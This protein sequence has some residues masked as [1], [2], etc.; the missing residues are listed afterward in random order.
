MLEEEVLV[1]AQEDQAREVGQ[2]PRLRCAQ[3]RCRAAAGA[4]GCQAAA[5]ACEGAALGR[6]RTLM[7]SIAPLLQLR[8]HQSPPRVAGRAQQ[9]R[10][11]QVASSRR[12]RTA[13]VAGRGCVSTRL[14]SHSSRQHDAR[15]FVTVARWWAAGARH[16]GVMSSRTVLQLQQSTRCSCGRAAR[17]AGANQLTVWLRWGSREASALAMQNEQKRARSTWCHPLV[18]GAGAGQAACLPALATSTAQLQ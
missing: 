3:A 18:R 5:G 1:R 14:W 17:A 2:E 8:L 13:P 16:L 11:P 12:G 6:G 7:S 9:H 15:V 10:A 4:C